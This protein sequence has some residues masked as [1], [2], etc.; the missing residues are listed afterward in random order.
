M[1]ESDMGLRTGE[2]SEM[3]KKSGKEVIQARFRI[4]WLHERS[5]VRRWL[6]K[7]T[8]KRHKVDSDH[9]RKR[10]YTVSPYSSMEDYVPTQYCVGTK[11]KKIKILCLDKIFSL[12]A[13]FAGTLVQSADCAL[14]QYCALT[15]YFP[16]TKVEWLHGINLRK[17]G[18]EDHHHHWSGLPR[19]SLFMTNPHHHLCI[20][21]YSP[22]HE[23]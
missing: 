6:S 5:D 21:T 8:K 18:N 2:A 19:F 16:W 1:K 7:R 3:R 22:L 9:V 17:K 14:T 11:Y 15:K 4:V 23:L 12:E 20:T 10:E 13:N